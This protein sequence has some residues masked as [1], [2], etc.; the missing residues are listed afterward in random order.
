MSPPLNNAA[1][2]ATAAA[3][4]CEPGRGVLAFS[5][6]VNA[7]DSR[8]PQRHEIRLPADGTAPAK[9]RAFLTDLLSA[10]GVEAETE[11]KVLLVASEL[12]TN[13]VVH[14][15]RGDDEVHVSTEID[16]HRVLVVVSDAARG[17]GVPFV[18]SAD[19]RRSSGRGLRLVE[20]HADWGERIV[21]GR[22]EVTAEIHR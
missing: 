20:Q 12:V 7:A 10:D 22:R 8:W 16:R 17:G 13:A 9:A 11:K 21:G 4:L 1:V 15:S 14:A 5:P 3:D 19:E 6:R 2:P 18:V